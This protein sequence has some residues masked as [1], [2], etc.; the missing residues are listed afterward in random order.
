M[1]KDQSDTKR[2]NTER[3]INLI[4]YIAPQ[5]KQQG[6]YTPSYHSHDLMSPLARNK[7]QL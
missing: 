3:K 6:T 5:K 1:K 4:Q 7:T 2:I